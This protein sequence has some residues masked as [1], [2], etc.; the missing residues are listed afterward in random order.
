MVPIHDTDLAEKRW[1]DEE[2]RQFELWEKIEVRFKRR[3]RRWIGVVA[4]LFLILASVPT[5]MARWPKWASLHAVRKVAEEVNQMRMDAIIQEASFRLTL[6]TAPGLG[7]RVERAERC[8]AP[9]QDWQIVRDGKVLTSSPGRLLARHLQVLASHEGESMGIPGL[10]TTVCVDGGGNADSLPADAAPE[11]RLTGVA[12]IPA[13]DFLAK[14][15]ERISV[16]SLTSRDDE[17]DFE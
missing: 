9:A 16:V 15:I 2:W 13:R 14:N 1:S 17:V 7:Y 6:D 3:R 11:F 12:V 8:N 5:V 10:R 4:I